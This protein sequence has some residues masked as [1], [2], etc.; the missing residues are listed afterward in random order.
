MHRD[1]DELTGH[2]VSSW[3]YAAQPRAAETMARM[4]AGDKGL[5]LTVTPCR[6]AAPAT[7]PVSTLL[8]AMPP[9]SP[10]RNGA[11]VRRTSAALSRTTARVVA[12]L[13]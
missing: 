5:D 1:V 4:R 9:S 11:A 10:P 6:R 12:S 8:V 3:G 7:A 2:A 13:R